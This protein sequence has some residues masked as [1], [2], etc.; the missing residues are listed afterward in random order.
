[1]SE[2]QKEYSRQLRASNIE[3]TLHPWGVQHILLPAREDVRR[4]GTSWYKSRLMTRLGY[5]SRST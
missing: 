4:E 3:L 5:F 1:M 2:Y